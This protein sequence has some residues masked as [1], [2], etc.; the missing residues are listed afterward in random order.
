MP[1]SATLKKW[2]LEGGKMQHLRAAGKKLVMKI[3]AQI[4]TYVLVAMG[5]FALDH[6]QRQHRRCKRVRQ[7]LPFRLSNKQL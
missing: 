2:F 1:Q 3:C 6:I 7:Y 5:R 4:L